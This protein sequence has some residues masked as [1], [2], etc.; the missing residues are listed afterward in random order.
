LRDNSKKRETRQYDHEF[1]R[2]WIA[3]LGER[4][5]RTDESN[6]ISIKMLNDA[7]RKLEDRVFKK[8]GN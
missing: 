4:I 1:Y 6:Q 8:R 7:I 2:I 5:A 3:P